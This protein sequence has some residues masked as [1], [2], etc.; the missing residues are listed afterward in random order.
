MSPAE[1]RDHS[2][3]ETYEAMAAVYDAFTAHF[4][5]DGWLADLL[6]ILGKFGLKGN[7]L[8]D[9]GC[10]TGESFIPMLKRGWTVHG[11]D[12][13]PAM[14]VRASE[15]VNGSV[16]LTS[17]DMRDLPRFGE[18]DLVW[19]LDDAVNYLLSVAELG[20]ALRG[21]RDNLAKDGLLVFDVNELLVYR[22]YYAEISE[23]E[24]DGRRF[25]WEGMGTPDVGPG[26]LCESR[27]EVLDLAEDAVMQKPD[28]VSIH[29]Q[30]HFPEAE[31][32]TALS[33]VGLECLAVFGQG[34]D[35]I[36]RQPL[37]PTSHTKA[38]YLARRA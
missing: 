38:L 7:R 34:L 15:K 16:D 24:R 25:I 11:C 12:L 30:K 32:R 22:S 6:E 17:A 10:G 28:C 37:D 27:L 4:D 33:A 13:S 21:M 3:L 29:R 20:S 26:S 18:F 31:I 23:L 35:G 19:A 1:T 8:L 36:P 9:V 2:A 5:T 14:L